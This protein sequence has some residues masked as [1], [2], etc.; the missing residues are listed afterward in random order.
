MASNVELAERYL[1]DFNDRRYSVDDLREYLAEDVVL[2]VPSTG[3]VF[4][5]YDGAIQF[6]DSWVQTFSDARVSKMTSVDRG[7]YVEVQFH[8]TGTFDGA[9]ITP[10]GTFTGDGSRQVD[11][12]FM[13]NFWIED[14]KI[15]R[16]EG[17]FDPNEMFRQ[18]GLG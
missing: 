14:G 4:H 3:Q 10:Q 15:T 12:P 8:G 2:E 9:L 1:Q 5:G 13:N 18:M 7:E 6:N 17:H 11:L 16:V